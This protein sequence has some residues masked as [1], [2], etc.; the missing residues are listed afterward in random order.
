MK[1]FLKSVLAIQVIAILSIALDIPVLRQVLGFFYTFF[2]P[3]LLILR[4]ANLKLRTVTE[5]VLLSIGISVT[6]SMFIGLAINELLPLAGISHPLTFLP[7]TITIAAILLALTFLGR[8][9]VG[10]NYSI[11]FSG[12]K[13]IFQ[14]VSLSIILLAAIVGALFIVSWLLLLMVLAICLVVVVAIFGRKLLPNEFYPLAILVI[15]LSLILQRELISQNI[16]GFDVF[17]E[18][19]VFKVTSLSGLWNPNLAI[20]VPQLLDY[21]SM[22][23]VTV[24]PTVLLNLSK[25]PSVW[26]FKVCYFLIY[27][28]VPLAIYEAYRRDFGRSIAFLSAF[29]FAFFPRF[30]IEERRQIIG[31]LFLVLLIFVILNKSLSSKWKSV[32]VGVFGIS[33]IVSHYSISYIFIFISLFAWLLLVFQQSFASILKRLKK[34]SIK[35]VTKVSKVL[36]IK[37]ILLFVLFAVFW[38]TFFSASLDKTFSSFVEHVIYTAYNGFQSTGAGGASSP[39]YTY[40]K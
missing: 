4:L 15:A 34:S 37:F 32:F 14:I 23:S 21:N 33:L 7:I 24:L 9:H 22:L 18:F 36:N 1:L 31:E 25:I 39:T 2:L 17:G 28:F 16:Y 13:L 29:Y 26:I 12:K 3:G 8:N 20:P 40:P 30:Y 5:T 38:Y 11:S 19:Y 10:W 27:I 35:Q 6:F